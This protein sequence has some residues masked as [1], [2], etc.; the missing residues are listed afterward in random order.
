MNEQQFYTIQ[1]NYKERFFQL[2]KV[3]FTNPI[4]ISVII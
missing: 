3:F 2:P 4:F 1:E